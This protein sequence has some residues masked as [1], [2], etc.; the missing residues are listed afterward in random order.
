MPDGVSSV[1]GS[2]KNGAKC[3]VEDGVAKLPDRTSFAGSVATFDRL[4][5]TMLLKT[6]IDII[7]VS[8]MASKTPATL[9]GLADRGEIAV[10][11]RA[12]LVILST[13]YCVEQ[14]IYSGNT[15]K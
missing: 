2:I 7:S 1:T 6:D 11:K 12:D 3:I 4:I 8:K 15:V 14:V 10:G 13:D 9:L 5:K